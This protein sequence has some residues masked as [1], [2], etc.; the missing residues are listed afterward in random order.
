MKDARNRTSGPFTGFE[1][2]DM[3]LND[4]LAESSQVR[5]QEGGGFDELL[6]SSGGSSAS[7]GA[8]G[9][10]HKRGSRNH[11]FNHTPACLQVKKNDWKAYK[12]LEEVRARG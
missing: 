1:L 5:V 6:S 2:L 9:L 8:G 11:S 3:L 10:L 7:A 12:P 4:T